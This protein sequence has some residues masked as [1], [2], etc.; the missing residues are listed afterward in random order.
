M[1]MVFQYVADTAAEC[2]V[3]FRDDVTAPRFHARAQCTA[4]EFFIRQVR[5]RPDSSTLH[6]FFTAPVF[7]SRRFL[8]FVF[9]MPLARSVVAVVAPL[10]KSALGVGLFVLAPLVVAQDA[11]YLNARDAVKNGQ[12]NKV[13]ALYPQLKQHEL[14]PYVESWLLKPQLMTDSPDIRAFLKKYGASVRP[15]CC[16]PMDSHSGQT[17]KMDARW[18][19]RGAL[20]LQ[21]EPDAAG[22]SLLPRVNNGDNAAKEQARTLWVTGVDSPDA[23]QALFEAMWVNR[24]VKGQRWL[25]ASAPPGGYEQIEIWRGKRWP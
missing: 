21:P 24:R 1:E 25:A 16:E 5:H 11:A 13:E 8:F 10:F 3:V 23:C 17:G 14:A 12:L 2:R 18:R 22:Y 9:K 20:M 15:N 6:L 7:I 4:I 19:N